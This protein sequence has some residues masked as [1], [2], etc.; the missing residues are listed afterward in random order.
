MIF[1]PLSLVPPYE[2]HLLY[3]SDPR[4]LPPG[5]LRQV[6]G[7]ELEAVNRTLSPMDEGIDDLTPLMFPPARRPR[8]R[9]A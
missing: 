9:P 3:C 1:V 6:A 4:V 8:R 2:R 5:H 7:D